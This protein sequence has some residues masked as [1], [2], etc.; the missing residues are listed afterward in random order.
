MILLMRRDMA[1]LSSNSVGAVVFWVG[2]S[3]QAAARSSLSLSSV[4]AH[5][6]KKVQRLLR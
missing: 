3:L 2:T 1:F 5:V 4:D 6:T